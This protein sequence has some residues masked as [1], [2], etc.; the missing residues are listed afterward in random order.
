MSALGKKEYTLAQST[1]KCCF[2]SGGMQPQAEPREAPSSP[3][4]RIA[5]P[6]TEANPRAASGQATDHSRGAEVRQTPDYEEAIQAAET[7]PGSTSERK[8]FLSTGTTETTRS[9]LDFRIQAS[10]CIYLVEGFSR[11]PFWRWTSRLLRLVLPSG[12]T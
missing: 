3:Q 7:Q 5:E 12:M 8:Q 9:I 4:V 2:S 1:R 10:S 6:Y 11:I